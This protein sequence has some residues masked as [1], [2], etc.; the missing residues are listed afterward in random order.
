VS[1]PRPTSA[2]ARGRRGTSPPRRGLLPGVLL[3]AVAAI[4]A[5]V[6]L[7]LGG[8]GSPGRDAVDRYLAA[9]T[10]GDDAAAAAA[11]DQLAA[12]RRAL[13]ASRAGLDGARVRAMVLDL[14]EDDDG[15]QARVRVSWQVPRIGTFAYV[16]RIAA[17]PAGDAWSVRWRETAV[18]PRLDE[19]T[20]LGTTVQVPARAPILDREGR[21]LMSERPVVDIA[22]E[23]DRVSSAEGSATALATLLEI[24]GEA[25][26]RRIENAGGGRFIPVI[27]LRLDEFTEQ[28]TA[29][30]AI[31]GVSTNQTTASLAPTRDFGRALLGSVGPV[32]AEQ[33]QRSDG[34]LVAGDV[35]GQSGLQAEHDAQLAGTPT[36]SVVIRTRETGFVDATLL[37]RPGRDGEALRTLLDRD[38]QAAAE[39][40]FDGVSLPG[41]GNAAL[42]ALQPSSGDVLA[43]VNRPGD[44][45]YDRALLGRY[46][47]GSTFKVVSTAALLRAGLSPDETVDC[48]PTL[49]VDGKSFRNFEGGAAGA[50]PFRDDFAHSCNTAFVSL[51]DRLGRRD[52]TDVGRAFGLGEQLAPGVPAAA[53]DVPPPRDAVGHAAMMIGQ[54]R[55]LASPLAMA[56][57]AATVASGR[58][59]APRLLPDAPRRAGPLL[60]AATVAT[61]REL[62]RAVVTGGTGTALAG[63][64]G[65]VRGKSGT[66]EYG[67]GDPPPTHAWFVATRDDLALAVLVE[68]G[69][70]GGRVA[71]PIAA[72]FFAALDAGAP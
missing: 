27:T 3:L 23:V 65:E 28:Q 51:A 37:R 53:A 35:A 44:S 52:L 24:D 60:D 14:Q 39:A 20:R 64:A 19:A 61:L 54:D 12:A 5:V 56:G 13:T 63:V 57:V 7:S 31:P 2:A 48:P 43:I 34:R 10:R 62:M 32:T 41:E 50:V 45:T 72:S 17:A 55:I 67:G 70:A 47:P 26:R 30:E 9:W 69:D 33:V 49:V 38:V 59:R 42:V 58:W 46:P 6:V 29:I 66:A 1:G 18:H 71:A 15:A 36:R 25:L 8:G 21:P 16:T 4:A 68:E 22:V 40:A 11:T